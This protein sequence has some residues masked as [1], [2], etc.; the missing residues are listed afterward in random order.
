MPQE[1]LE[2][3]SSQCL[4]LTHTLP[5]PNLL[6]HTASL[7]PSLPPSLTSGATISPESAGPSSIPIS[8]D[9]KVAAIATGAVEVPLVVPQ[10]GTA[11][12]REG[13]GKGER[14]KGGKEGGRHEG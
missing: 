12:G 5:L 6:S 3:V 7:P 8:L 11:V 1:C 14:G 9:A 4:S 10:S 13:G 2:C